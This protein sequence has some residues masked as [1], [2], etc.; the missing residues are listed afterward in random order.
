[1]GEQE[2]EEEMKEESEWETDEGKLIKWIVEQGNEKRE[3]GKANDREQN[4]ENL[5]E[6]ENKMSW[7]TWRERAREIDEKRKEKGI[8][9]R[10]KFYY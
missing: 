1:M 3:K 8:L 5:Q 6:E 9:K 10:R 4:L 2:E 7:K